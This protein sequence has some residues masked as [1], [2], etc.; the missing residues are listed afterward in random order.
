MCQ[1]CFNRGYDDYPK[2][3]GSAEHLEDYQKGF[4]KRQQEDGG[5]AECIYETDFC[6]KCFQRGKSDYQANIYTPPTTKRGHKESYDEGYNYVDS[7]REKQK[8]EMMAEQDYNE[9]Q[10]RLNKKS[11]K[12]E[13][14]MNEFLAKII[15]GGLVIIGLLWVV[16]MVALPL[17][18]I[19]ISIISL[20][21]ALFFRR[22]W[23]TFLL[24][25][26]VLGAIFGIIDFNNGLFTLALAESVPFLESFIPIFFYLNIAS[27]L[28]ALYF[29]L[30]MLFLKPR[31]KEGI[32]FMND[33]KRLITISSIALLGI[34]TIL[35]QRLIFDKNIYKT[36]SNADQLRNTNAAS[37]GNSTQSNVQI[38][39]YRMN[40]NNYDEVCENSIRNLIQAEDNRDFTT[41]YSYISPNI[42]RYW[43]AVSPSQEELYKKYTAVWNRLESSSNTI[44]EI[45]KIDNNTFD[46]HNTF[47]YTGKNTHETKSINSVVRFKFDADGKIIFI[48][49]V[50]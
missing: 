15:V 29:L 45:N 11:T 28:M 19:N 38:T 9:R 40:D 5:S 36:A 31:Q 42:E 32:S 8:Q 22:N 47:T 10:R 33:K 46:L 44:N 21:A 3:I 35:L 14:T 24:P 43:D 2:F 41:I 27:G 23:Q 49:E 7:K 48:N 34:T 37:S 20:I 26:S 39:P 16:I 12:E 4:N 17:I 50:R 25:L 30:D 13:N 6:D 1:T 18:V